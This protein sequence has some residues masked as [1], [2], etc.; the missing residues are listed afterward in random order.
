MKEHFK[1]TLSSFFIITTLINIA[2][3]V[4]GM[5]F[6]P[7]QRFGYEVFIYPPVNA[8]LS[9]IPTLI[10]Y[11]KKELTLRQIIIRKIIQLMMI[12]VL[13]QMFIFGGGSFDARVSAG[14]TISVI[15]IFITV[16]LIQW[17]L[18]SKTAKQMTEELREYQKKLSSEVYSK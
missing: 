14:V 6:R 16:H 3:L 11:S 12:I 4:L 8:A 18:D 1:E 2:M 15:F 7:N 10:M 17:Y 9:C 5:L 13:M